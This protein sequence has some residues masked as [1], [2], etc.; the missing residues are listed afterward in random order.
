MGMMARVRG[1]IDRLRGQETTI[2]KKGDELLGSIAKEQARIQT[3]VP[4]VVGCF[5]GYKEILQTYEELL[6]QTNRIAT[7][8]LA[9]C[10]QLVQQGTQAL[11][12]KEALEPAGKRLVE[13]LNMPLAERNSDAKEL[14]ERV[15]QVV[16]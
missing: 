8:L 10:D 6:R 15:K 11:E 7:A 16:H 3:V 14:L 4:A 9:D 1:D 13:L 12:E 2:R 5:S